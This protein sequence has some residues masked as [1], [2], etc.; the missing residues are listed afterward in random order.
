[1][2]PITISRDAITAETIEIIIKALM[3]ENQ[4]IQAV[5]VYMKLKN[6]E[7]PKAFDYVNSL[8]A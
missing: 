5:N 8:D 1:M 7:F 3:K 4:C 2:K 6:C